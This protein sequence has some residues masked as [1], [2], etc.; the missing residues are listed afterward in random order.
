[1]NGR[2]AKILRRMA[3]DRDMEIP[4]ATRK[5]AKL[6]PWWADLLRRMRRAGY[7][8]WQRRERA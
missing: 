2:R 8:A 1:M 7:R 3:Y 4:E 5:G 6:V